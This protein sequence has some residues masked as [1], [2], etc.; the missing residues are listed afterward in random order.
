MRWWTTVASKP[1]PCHDCGQWHQ[2]DQT[3]VFERER[4]LV[5]CPSCAEARGVRAKRSVNHRVTH[6]ERNA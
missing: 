2:A 3:V 5:I 4:K 1:G 6:P